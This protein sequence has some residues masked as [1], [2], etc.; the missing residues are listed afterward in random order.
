VR[1]EQSTKSKAGTQPMLAT[2]VVFIITKM[3]TNRSCLQMTNRRSRKRGR[4]LEPKSMTVLNM[5]G[6]KRTSE[7]KVLEMT[8]FQAD[9]GGSSLMQ[10]QRNVSEGSA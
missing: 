10:V 5:T 7:E 1:A 9:Y 4:S 2:K 8:N 6:K 3:R